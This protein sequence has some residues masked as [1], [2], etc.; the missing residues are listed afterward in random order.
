MNTQYQRF[1]TQKHAFDFDEFVYKSTRNQQILVFM[2]MTIFALVRIV[3]TLL[4]GKSFYLLYGGGFLIYTIILLVISYKG[5]LWIKKYGNLVTC[6]VLSLIQ[7]QTY[8]INS[9]E[10][11]E[12]NSQLIMIFLMIIYSIL[13]MK[14]ACFQIIIFI[15]FKIWIQISQNGNFS[16]MKLIF[17]LLEGI[18]IGVYVYFQ[19]QGHNIRFS[20]ECF[21]KQLFRFLP[22]LIQNQFLMFNLDEQSSSFHLRFQSEITTI[23]WDDSNAPTSNLRSF[24][25]NTYYEDQSLEQ[26]ILSRNNLFDNNQNYYYSQNLIVQNLDNNKSPLNLN[27]VE[28]FLGQK[29]YL[30]TFNENKYDYLE[31]INNSLIACINRNQQLTISFLKKQLNQICTIMTSKMQIQ[32]LAK[33]KIHCMYFLGQFLQINSF[34]TIDH[35]IKDINLTKLLQLMVNLYCNAYQPI[36]IELQSDEYCD[37]YIQSN[38]EL[39][40]TF[41]QI[42]CQL[43]IRLKANELRNQI[44]FG[45]D[46]ENPKLFYVIVRTECYEEYKR[47]LENNPFFQKI[48]R[49]L[50]P[51]LSILTLNQSVK[52]YL[53]KNY[54]PLE[55]IRELEDEI[56]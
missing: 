4:T 41:F 44:I 21:Q 11:F 38:E 2:L 33:L 16:I 8:L 46:Q 26:Y 17:Q 56:I 37:F 13:N 20:Q 53:Y 39:I 22:D 32:L 31:S 42:L 27:Y 55:E 45:Q 52:F 15:G 54:Q 10:E 25:R 23:K 19:Q 1:F 43:L 29:Y 18:T 48:Q 6:C 49:R 14:G 47:Q 40:Q 28:C 51:N 24:L 3:S 36:Q 5:K 35:K 30:I 9:I 7:I 34:S 50:C 12:Q